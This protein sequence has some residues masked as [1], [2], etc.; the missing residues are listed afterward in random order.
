[1][2][3]C[4]VTKIGRQQHHSQHSGLW[5]V[6]TE[7]INWKP[8]AA[9][10]Y[11]EPSYVP[12]YDHS[13]CPRLTAACTDDGNMACPIH[14][15][16]RCQLEAQAADCE[17]SL[18]TISYHKSCVKSFPGALTVRAASG[19]KKCQYGTLSLS[20]PLSPSPS[21]SLLSSF[22]CYTF[23]PLPCPRG[24]LPQIML[25]NLGNAV[26]STVGPGRARPTNG[27]WCI[28]SWKSCSH[29]SAFT[30]IV[31]HIRTVTYLYCISQKRTNWQYVFN[32]TK[33]VLVWHTIPLPAL[34][35]TVPP[36]QVHIC[37]KCDTWEPLSPGDGWWLL[38]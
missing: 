30:C 20:L 18:L 5:C 12:S 25:G 31:I 36:H 38:T 10:V 22:L 27:F 2:H 33:E 14:R 8:K 19:K 21:S 26:S 17:M 37:D 29:D 15:Y 4:C 1:M 35:T 24:P 9:A 34:L 3:S 13:H 23:V 28:L 32:L 16:H 7:H 11:H 6:C